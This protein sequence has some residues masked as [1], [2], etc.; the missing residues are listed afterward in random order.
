MVTRSQ[1]T[2]KVIEKGDMTKLGQYFKNWGAAPDV[3]L[4]ASWF[5]LCFYFGCRAREGWACMTFTIKKDS[6]G[7]EYVTMNITE[8]TKNHQGGHKMSRIIL[9]F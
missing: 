7:N 3:L 6:D 5:F 4:E 9:M 1:S 2:K 8:T